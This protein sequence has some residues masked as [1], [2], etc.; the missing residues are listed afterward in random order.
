MS[1]RRIFVDCQC[2]LSNLN[3][4][5]NSRVMHS[6]DDNKIDIRQINDG[7]GMRFGVAHSQL[8][9]ELGF[10]GG[11]LSP[12]PALPRDSAWS[13]CSAVGRPTQICVPEERHAAHAAWLTLRRRACLRS[14]PARSARPLGV[15]GSGRDYVPGYMSR[16]IPKFRTNKFDT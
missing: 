7:I 3:L 11:W 4:Y 6:I 2:G 13:C 16:Q 12:P 5:F 10:S 9:S 14:G 8:P 1:D 15:A